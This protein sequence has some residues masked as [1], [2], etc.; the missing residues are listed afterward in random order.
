MNR[1]ILYTTILIPLVTQGQPAAFNFESGAMPAPCVLESKRTAEPRKGV[2]VQPG[3]DEAR[4]GSVMVTG[5]ASRGGVFIRALSD[6]D[7]LGESLSQLT[8]CLAFRASPLSAS[9]VFL[10]RIVGGTSRN[11]GVFRFRSQS[12]SK[13]DHERR[14]TLRLYVGN[15]EG[16]TVTATSTISWI[17]QDNVWNWV[18]M[19][20]DK[21]RVVFYLN[22]E[23]LGD[24]VRLSVEEIPSPGE[25]SYYLRSGY[26][27]VGAFDDL[28]IIP[29]KAF[30]DE[31]MSAIYKQGIT[32]EETI[33]KLK[34]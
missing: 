7:T 30:T 6:D 10:E 25:S 33:K 1:L 19:V 34:E 32:S 23:R 22:G 9:P 27:F 28:V 20:F 4:A 12:N 3:T 8:V 14:G 2:A 13:D 31:D 5:D 16:Q 18:G 29:G 15:S 11:P 21:G 26:G 24:E 17:Q